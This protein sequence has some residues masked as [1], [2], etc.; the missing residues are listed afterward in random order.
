MID[1]S[2]IDPLELPSVPLLNRKKLY[3]WGGVYFLIRDKRD[4]LYIG[5]SSLIKDRWNQHQSLRYLSDDEQQRSRIHWLES[6]ENLKQL[7]AI[8]I[9]RFHPP[10]NRYYPPLNPPPQPV[11]RKMDIMKIIFEIEVKGL[12]QALKQAREKAKLSVASAGKRAGMSGANFSRIE[13]EET[14]GV[15]VETLIK[16]AKAVELDLSYYL[17]KWIDYNN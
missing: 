4:I 3:R 17:G 8:F 11:A 16:A 6:N 9:H 2:L 7:E 14:K 15:P 13:N 1:P 12:G 10:L 5:Q